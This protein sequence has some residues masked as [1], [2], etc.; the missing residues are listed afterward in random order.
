MRRMIIVTVLGGAV[1]AYLAYPHGVLA[2]VMAYLFGGACFALLAFLSFW[3]QER[4]GGSQEAD[5]NGHK[6][7]TDISV[8]MADANRK[9]AEA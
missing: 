2:A 7:P 6:H 4:L 8:A 9:D 1:S 3:V 5:S